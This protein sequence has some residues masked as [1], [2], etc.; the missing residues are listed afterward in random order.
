MAERDGY[1]DTQLALRARA[2]ATQ[3]F[4]RIVQFIEDAPAPR[5]EF[6]AFRRE[7]YA[8]GRAIEQPRTEVFFERRHV[9]ARCRAR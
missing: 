5:Q 3:G 1:I 4:L 6:V 7:T 8:T 2:R 9:C